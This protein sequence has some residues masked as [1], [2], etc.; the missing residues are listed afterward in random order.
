V[1]TRD[2][3]AC[4]DDDAPYNTPRCMCQLAPDGGAPLCFFGDSCEL[5]VTCSSDT[6]SC[7]Y[8][9]QVPTNADP[10]DDKFNICNTDSDTPERTKAFCTQ[11]TSSASTAD[12]PLVGEPQKSSTTTVIVV[13]LF[14]LLAV[15]VAALFVV[16]KAGGGSSDNMEPISFEN[17]MYDSVHNSQGFNEAVYSDTAGGTAGGTGT[18]GYTDVNANGAGGGGGE[19]AYVDVSPLYSGAESGDTAPNFAQSGSPS[20]YFDISPAAA[21]GGGGAGGMTAAAYMD[22]SPP[23][24]AGG[25]GGAGSIAGYMDVSAGGFADN[26]SSDEDV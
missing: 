16:R 3:N 17:R 23:A 11:P 24:A 19:A 12:R 10:A 6:L 18:S 5:P 4:E 14:V 13:A 26:L 22:I 25:G 8:R 15:V 20:A 1:L 9:R 7:N 21:A 2:P